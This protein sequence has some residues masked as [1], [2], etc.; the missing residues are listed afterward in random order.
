MN[1]KRGILE[2]KLV[3]GKK[4]LLRGLLATAVLLAFHS[5][6]FSSEAPVYGRYQVQ[7]GD[8]LRSISERLLG[9]PKRWKELY[10]LN[11][12]T[13]GE[14]P[15]RLKSDSV[16]LIPLS[17]ERINELAQRPLESGLPSPPPAEGY[18]V[19][20]GDTLIGIARRELDDPSLWREIYRENREKIG[21][22]PGVL[23]KGLSLSLPEKKGKVEK[24]LKRCY[25]V[26]KGDTLLSIA[27]S[28]LGDA[29]QWKKL[30]RDNKPAI[31]E[32]PNVLKV[33]LCLCLPEARYLVKKGDT[34]LSIAGTVLGDRRRWHE[35][36]LLNA[37]TIGADPNA[38]RLG[39]ELL[40]P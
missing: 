15:D 34:L 3:S 12:G 13:I 38:L 6:V 7:P 20:P 14:D 40:I 32:N 35:L 2:R 21:E 22:D 36:Y 4:K 37:E 27:R 11:E 24:N 18:L 8:T 33:G 23:K 10:D 16:L 25:Q 5:P 31:G 9:D 29:T 26:K 17:D 30:Y 1:P 19:K 39:T 28:V